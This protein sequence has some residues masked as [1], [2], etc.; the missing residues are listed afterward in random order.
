VR[1]TEAVH[2]TAVGVTTLTLA[3]AFALAAVVNALD[4]GWP[5]W[6]VASVVAVVALG[7]GWRRVPVFALLSLATA[8]A[9]AAVV[10][11]LDIGWPWWVVASV[12]AVVAAGLSWGVVYYPLSELSE[13]RWSREL[14][15]YRALE[16]TWG[17]AREAMP[18]VDYTL[19]HKRT[20]PI[21]VI[22]GLFAVSLGSLGM[23]TSLD[24]SS[25]GS[26][27][28]YAVPLSFG[29]LSFVMGLMLA[30][31][32]RK[33]LDVIRK[34]FVRQVEAALTF[35]TLSLDALVRQRNALLDSGDVSDANNIIVL[36]RDYYRLR[37]DPK[38][39]RT[40]PPVTW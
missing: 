3:T 26:I 17:R 13:R 1:A 20:P 39:S 23:S 32:R 5:W 6:V 18:H 33:V 2:H 8:F 25:P 15:R 9:L 35:D 16:R 30:R 10:N 40:P 11:A 12:V 21:A 27:V 34:N 37:E 19:P 31:A 7:L 36:I 28:A 24:D 22:V 14:E 29:A 38:R 4:I